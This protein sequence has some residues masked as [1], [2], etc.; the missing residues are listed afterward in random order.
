[1]TTIDDGPLLSADDGEPEDGHPG[2]IVFRWDGARV[3]YSDAMLG[4]GRAYGSYV[5]T[6][7]AL[8]DIRDGLKPVQRR[9]I[10]AM[11]DL[12]LRS[13]R[14]YSKSAKTV[15]TVIG[16][17]H[18]HGD[19]AVYDAMVRMAQPWQSNLPLIDGQGNW[20]NL[21]NEAPAAAQRY[22]ESRLSPAATDFLSDLRPE[23]VDYGWNFDETRQMPTVLPVTFPNLLVNGSMGV[24]WAMACS[25]PPHNTA[26]VLS[27]ALLVL[28][29]PDV[30]L[31]RLLEVMPGPDLPGGGIVVNPGNLRSIYETG[32]GTVLVQGRIEQLPGQQTLRISELPYQVSAKSIV[33][34]AVQAAK[35]GKITEIF[36][37]E[38][39]KN[40]TDASGV[41]VQ[42]KCKR[43]GSIQKLIQE[44]LQYT[45]LRDTLAFNLTV[46]VDNAPQTVSLRQ[47]LQHFV[48]FRRQVVTRRLT[49]ERD[50]LLK[51]L[52]LLLAERAA[53]DVIDRVVQIVRTADDDDD[54]KRKLIAELKYRPH[55][56]S[57]LVPIDDIQAQHI[58]DMAL[59]K[60]NAL[61]QLKIDEELQAKAARVDE[62]TA[63]LTAAGGIDGIVRAEMDRAREQFGQP[64]RTVIPGSDVAEAMAAS[65]AAAANGKSDA[66]AVP[67]A[68][69]VWAYVASNGA[70]LLTPRTG[71]PVT[72]AP[73]R[74]ADSA[75]LTAVVAARSDG[76]LLLF[77]AQGRAYRV[78]LSDH[79]VTRAGAG[80]PVVTPGRDPI[81]VAFSGPDAPYYLLVTAGGQI[82][83]VPG[84]TLQPAHAAGIVCCRVPDGDKIVAVVPHG[85][86]D[87]ILIAKANGQVLRIET[88]TKLRAVPTPGAGTVAGVKVDAGDR[89]VSAVKAAGTSLLSI[90]VSGMALAVDLGEYPAKGRGTGGVQS[91]LT[92]RPAK[93]PAGDLALIACLAAETE[94]AVFSARG[95]MAAIAEADNP[96]LRR[97]TNSRP[98]LAL[99]SGDVPAGQVDVAETSG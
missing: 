57:R 7:R 20:G 16:N 54:S 15:G 97:A 88:G 17:Y 18:P 6:S 22:T 37:A 25:I 53:A 34:Q 26:E 49:Y 73:L 12:G 43:G 32:R 67:P 31:D 51:R 86:D 83:R 52:H 46:L 21:D 64:R 76:T 1:M 91:V 63:I 42:I 72:A 2:G 92:D 93:A 48:D 82:K 98:L 94:V 40:L 96:V 65:A 38:L 74:L 27:A 60:I 68:E 3:D 8:P 90:H 23:I 4:R 80:R 44:L 36:T 55:G 78:T 84:Q 99:D 50:V 62:I 56:Q 13:D 19:S 24:A 61:N 58:I 11:N 59:K 95:T 10:V 66:L 89:V 28:D 33:E 41:D 30:P 35:D 75:A 47:I 77:S 29:D 9:I 71:Q 79:P 85:E 45:K 81:A 39:P 70:L 69:G 14:R 87:D 5:L